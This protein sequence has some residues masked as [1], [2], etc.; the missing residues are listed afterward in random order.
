MLRI[1][2]LKFKKECRKLRMS[3]SCPTST[4]IKSSKLTKNRNS[5]E[6]IIY[7]NN[8]WHT[9]WKLLSKLI[10]YRLYWWEIRQLYKFTIAIYLWRLYEIIYITSLIKCKDLVA[11]FNRFIRCFKCMLALSKELY[12]YLINKDIYTKYLILCAEIFKL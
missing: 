2:V 1:E 11:L 6:K 4:N 8:M 7:I 12:Y 10:Y 9:L 5:C 3:S